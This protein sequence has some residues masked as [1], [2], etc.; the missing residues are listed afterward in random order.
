M[1]INI[2]NFERQTTILQNTDNILGKLNAGVGKTPRRQVFTT[3]GTWIAPVGV[4]NVFIT[5][6]GGGGGGGLSLPSAMANGVSGGITSFGTLLSLSGGGGGR[7]SASADWS[8]LGGSAGGK[9][10]QA[11][12]VISRYS[13]ANLNG[14]VGDGGNSGFYFGGRG[15]IFPTPT[16]ASVIAVGGYCSG[17]GGCMSGGANSGYAVP[18]GGGGEFVINYPLTVVPG[19]NYPITIGLG[20]LGGVNGVAKGGNGGQGILIIE[21]WE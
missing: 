19:T 18:G 10:G 12:E 13:T 6:G 14:G 16:D 17:G 4:T 7:T 5:G 1:A 15:S 3:N 21:W 20:G 9:G 8:A 11:G 2:A